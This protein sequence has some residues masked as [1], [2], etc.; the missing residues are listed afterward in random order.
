RPGAFWVPWPPV[1]SRRTDP[2][3][4][5][6]RFQSLFVALTALAGLAAGLLLPIG[7]AAGHL[8]L[9]T[10]LMMLTAV[11]VQMDAAHMGKVRRA[12]AL[13]AT[14]LVLNFAFTPALAWALGAGLLGD[15]PDLRIGL[16]LLLVTP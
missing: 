16:L 9:P 12:K 14:S 11:F 2:L 4:L 5:A 1:P 10:L 15:E 8:V 7:P 13:V 3:S 6:E